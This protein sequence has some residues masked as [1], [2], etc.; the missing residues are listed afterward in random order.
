MPDFPVFKSLP[1]PQYLLHDWDPTSG[2]TLEDW[3]Q[4]LADRGWHSWSGTGGT[5]AVINGRRVYRVHLRRDARHLKAEL[6]EQQAAAAR[7]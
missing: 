3:A 2:V 6:A 7:R 1:M 4:D 5:W